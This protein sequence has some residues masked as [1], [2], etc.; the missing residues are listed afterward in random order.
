MQSEQKECEHYPAI[1]P[2]STLPPATEGRPGTWRF[3]SYNR[4]N[5]YLHLN[6]TLV[7]GA[8]LL[9]AGTHVGASTLAPL[10]VEGRHFV[11][12]SGRVVILRGVNVSGDAKVPPFLPNL[13]AADFDRLQS[14]GMNVVRLLMIWEAYEPSP[15]T[16]N[17]AYIAGLR[18]I[19]LTASSRG[20]YVIIDIH[21][22]G[23]SRFAS[24]GSGDGFPAWAVSP[25]GTLSRPDNG[26][27]CW[28]WPFLMATDRTTHRSFA[29]FFSDANG[30]RSRYLAM[31]GR[32]AATF[33]GVPGVIG[34]DLMN[35]P[36]GDERRDLAPL[37]RDAAMVVRGADPAAILFLEGQISTN[38]G[39]QSRLP[40]PDFGGVVY[41]PH[42]YRPLTIALNE[43][44]GTSFGMHRAF[45]RMES[46]VR[47]WNAPLFVGEFGVGATAHRAGDYV[48]A[49]YD[50]LDA[51]L[52]SGAQWNYCPGWSPERKDGWN[53]E[54]FAMFTPDG[55]PRPNFRPRPY[56]RYTAGEPYRFRY[57]AESRHALEFVWEHH[58]EC[59]NTEIF[60]PKD[61]FP[62]GSLIEC[63]PQYVRY[64]HDL[65]RNV[66]VFHI[67]RQAT[68]C[69]RIVGAGI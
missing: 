62:A 65:S 13:Q 26:P 47:E 21:Q 45:S 23:F 16:Y 14:L 39:L 27:S 1:A 32:V 3:D 54:D 42:Y 55:R 24:R 29:D 34:Y 66:V 35:E 60:V 46:K 12:T 56:P 59:G 25:R 38:C 30:T 44:H 7:L 22:D 57:Q 67:D 10:R 8:F 4:R 49:I 18:A 37:Y 61:E 17:E 28:A 31:L 9:W 19:A 2:I 69:V 33:A 51:S 48:A 63:A 11:D 5:R 68:I 36:W 53:G 41:S 58:P 40:R 43:W 64:H 52:A 6:K 50:C 15:G 20:M